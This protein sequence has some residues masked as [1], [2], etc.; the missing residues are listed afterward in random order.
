MADRLGAAAGCAD[1]RSLRRRGRVGASLLRAG[2][3]LGDDRWIDEARRRERRLR[4]YPYE[5][6]DLYHGTAGRL[7][8]IVLLWQHTGDPALPDH[9]RASADALLA[10]A[11]AP[12]PDELCWTIGEGYGGFS[13]LTE[14]GYAHGGFSGLSEPGVRASFW[15]R[16]RPSPP[17]PTTAVWTGGMAPASAACGATAPPGSDGCPC[18]SPPSASPR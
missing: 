5:M 16:A 4:D 14:P 13:G 6:P 1:R 2:R 3:V 7:R 12:R 8:F 18:A 11:T 17:C 10:Q 15:V 9:A